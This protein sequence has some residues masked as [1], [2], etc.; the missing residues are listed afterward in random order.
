MDRITIPIMRITAGFL[1]AL[2]FM[3]LLPAHA[4]EQNAQEQ[5]AQEE[6]TV[7]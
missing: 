4:Q 6:I 7:T 1:I 2:G 3:L 5:K